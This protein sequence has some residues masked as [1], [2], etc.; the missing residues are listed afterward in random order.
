MKEKNWSDGWNSVNRPEE[1]FVDEAPKPQW[2][3]LYDAQGNALYLQRNPVG[4]DTD[5]TRN[6]KR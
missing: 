3:G 1:R 4:F 6:F 2:S 5:P